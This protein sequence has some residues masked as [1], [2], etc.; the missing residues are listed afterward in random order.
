MLYFTA[1]YE[2]I[3]RCETFPQTSIVQLARGGSEEI[4]MSGVLKYIKLAFNYEYWDYYTLAVSH[5]LPFVEVL[6]VYIYRHLDINRLHKLNFRIFN[7]P[8]ILFNIRK[9]GYY[10]MHH[11]ESKRNQKTCCSSKRR[12]ICWRQ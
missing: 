11:R 9:M 7:L 8:L 5:F 12:L 4:S 10:G 2:L 3:S 1:G 6:T